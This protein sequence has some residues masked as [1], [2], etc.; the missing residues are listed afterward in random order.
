M[1]NIAT[2]YCTV[3]GSSDEV[4]RFKQGTIKTCS[5]KGKTETLFD[6]AAIIPVPAIIEGTESSTSVDQGL[7]HLGHADLVLKRFLER[8]ASFEEPAIRYIERLKAIPVSDPEGVAKA[9]VGIQAFMETGSMDWYDWRCKHWGT[10]W[11]SD[12]LQVLSDK[13][14]R[15]EFCFDTAW[16]FP[17]PIFE[18]LAQM[19]PDLNFAIETILDDNILTVHGT[20]REGKLDLQ[21]VWRSEAESDG[22]LTVH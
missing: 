10:K 3:T 19:F 18:K 14:G 12:N 16:R 17:V 4:E 9:K 7:V 2:T 13:P 20:I 15:Y 11:N 5:V 21:K 8:D 1:P 6:F 22:D